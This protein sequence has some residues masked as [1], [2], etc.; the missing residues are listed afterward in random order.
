MSIARLRAIEFEKNYILEIATV[1][2]GHHVYWEDAQEYDDMYLCDDSKQ[3]A[4]HLQIE[5]PFL[6]SKI[7]FREGC[8]LEFSPAGPRML[9]NGP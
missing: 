5:L 9:E 8:S 6:M 1:C 3:V 2:R 7:I 4:R